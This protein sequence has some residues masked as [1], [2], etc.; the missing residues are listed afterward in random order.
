MNQAVALDVTT[1]NR[2]I[3]LVSLLHTCR[4]IILSY[5]FRTMPNIVVQTV[6]ISAP[7]AFVSGFLA[8]STAQNLA[9]H[10]VRCAT[11]SPLPLNWYS[12]KLALI[13]CSLRPLI[14]TCKVGSLHTSL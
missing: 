7:I 11:Q 13:R 2:H 1:T 10:K 14:R 9:L 8:D 4:Q 12:A 6:A 5:S 3:L